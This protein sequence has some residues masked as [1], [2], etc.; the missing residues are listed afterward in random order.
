VKIP[1]PLVIEIDAEKWTAEYPDV[2]GATA[3]RKDVRDYLLNQVFVGLSS[4]FGEDNVAVT[5]K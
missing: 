1:V 2:V 5:L 4:M 3:V